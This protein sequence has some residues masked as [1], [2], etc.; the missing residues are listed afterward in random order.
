MTSGLFCWEFFGEGGS[1]GAEV[2]Q[3]G[4]SCESVHLKE[5]EVAR[6]F[7][8]SKASKAGLCPWP[9]IRH[10]DCV[11]AFK[12][13]FPRVLENLPIFRFPRIRAGKERKAS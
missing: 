7:A 1:A 8:C 12:E 10:T 2:V 11:G 3:G 5:G 9:L 13:I 4:R 6:R